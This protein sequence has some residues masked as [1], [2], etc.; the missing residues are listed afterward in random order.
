MDNEEI[1]DSLTPN[2][3]EGVDNT[4][5]NE[6]NPHIEEQTELTEEDYANVIDDDTAKKMQTAIAQKKRWR[7]KYESVKKEL[8]LERSK[9][10]VRVEETKTEIKK[11][12]K[13]QINDFHKEIA[14]IE[15]KQEFPS[16]NNDE[17]L[18][19]MKYSEVEGKTPQ[20][21]INSP[22]FQ[23]VIK[24]RKE[25]EIIEKGTPSPTGRS[26]TYV[27]NKFDKVIENPSLVKSLSSDEYKKF[28][29]WRERNGK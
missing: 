4:T 19:A 11:E 20:E 21:V 3:N 14:R 22:Y 28:I 15:L 17:V 2:E 9:S 7:E 23:A 13:E 1:K 12:Q 18:K 5:E 16:L 24:E 6:L 10:T 8:E 26:G 27:S 25:R 29:E